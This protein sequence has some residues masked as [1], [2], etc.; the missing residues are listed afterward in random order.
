[1]QEK[2]LEALSRRSAKAF[3]GERIIQRLCAQDFL[4]IND[5]REQI[6]FAFSIA[7]AHEVPDRE[8]FFRERS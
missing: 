4:F 8:R 6:D 5:L 1:M 3:I 7:V 2:M